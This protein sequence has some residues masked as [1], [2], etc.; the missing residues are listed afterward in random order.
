MPVRRTTTVPP[1]SELCR[2]SGLITVKKLSG[3]RPGPTG[4]TVVYCHCTGIV[5]DGG[6][7]GVAPL[8]FIPL[9]NGN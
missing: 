6:G 4:V 8:S 5:K 1:F 7:G 3:T 9:V 2:Y